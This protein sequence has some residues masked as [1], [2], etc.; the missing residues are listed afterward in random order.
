MGALSSAPI[1][2]ASS[3]D[4]LYLQPFGLS[5]PFGAVSKALRRLSK[6]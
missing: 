4:N 6:I 1:F 2:V 5:R 3:N